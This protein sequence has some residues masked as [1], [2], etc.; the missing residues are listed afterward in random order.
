MTTEDG[1]PFSVYVFF[2]DDSWQKEG[3]GLDVVG[4]MRLVSQLSHSVGARM[5]MVQR[6]II[7]DSGDSTCL[8]WKP[9]L[10]ITFPKDTRDG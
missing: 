7:T 6:I 5:G 3:E 1:Y 10:G 8:E 2:P 9:G 4:A